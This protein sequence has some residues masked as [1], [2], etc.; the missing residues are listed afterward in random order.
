MSKTR[1]NK[2]PRALLKAVEKLRLKFGERTD[3]HGFRR[4][5]SQPAQDSFTQF[6][7]D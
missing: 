3:K 5:K 6:H 4:R 1:R 7:L 2:K